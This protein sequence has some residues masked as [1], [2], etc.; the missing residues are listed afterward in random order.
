MTLE[1]LLAPRL[2]QML[3]V[4]NLSYPDLVA[5]ISKEAEENPV[6]EVERCDEFAEFI[7]YLSSDK[8]LRKEGD[9]SELPGLENIGNVEKSLVDHLLEQLELADLAPQQV[10]IAKEII[11]NIDDFGYVINY[12]AVRERLMAKHSLSRPTID[13]VL[14][15]VQGFEPDGVGARDLKECL[16]IQ[17]EQYNFENEELQALLTEVVEKYL[18]ALGEQKFDAIAKALGLSETAVSEIAS[19]IK[20]NLNPQPGASFGGGTRHVIP[21]F[22]VEKAGDKYVLINLEERYGPKISLSAHYLKMLESPKSDAATKEF[23]KTKLKRAKELMEDFHKRG[24]TLEKIVRKIIATQ[25]DFLAEGAGWLKPL[26]QNSLANEFGLHPSTISRSVAEKYIQTPQGLW[27][28]KYLCPRGPKGM[29]VNRI[30]SLLAEI[31][32]KEDKSQP[33]S[34]SQITGLMTERGARIDR[35]TIAYYRQELKIPT[36]DQRGKN[37]TKKGN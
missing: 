29:T 28:L 4:L 32:A 35:R 20:N 12:P 16:L 13:K 5:E 30:K 7:R 14:K 18:T 37:D 36:A 22:A 2:L 24:E 27:P 21:S 1:L 8:R 10:E 11:E 15:I 25:E 17:I 3:K 34:D 6:M 9:F 31:V 33:L 19:F 23:I 26:T